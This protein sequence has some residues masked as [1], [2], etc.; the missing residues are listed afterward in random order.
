[1]R[2]RFSVVLMRRCFFTVFAM[3]ILFSGPAFAY[4]IVPFNSLR[5][6]VET[7]S[8]GLLFCPLG[9][10]DR[11][12]FLGD[13]AAV[14]ERLRR[15]RPFDETDPFSFWV[16]EASPAEERRLFK[17]VEGVPP[18]LV[19]RELLAHVPQRLKSVHYKIVLI[20][21]KGSNSCAEFSSIDKVSVIILGRLRDPDIKKFVKV[22]LHELGHSLGLRDERYQ[23]PHDPVPGPPNCAST[24]DEA[25][26]WWGDLARQYPERVGFFPGCCGNTGY[27]RPVIASIMNEPDKAEDFGPVNESYLEK[28]L[29]KKTL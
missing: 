6:P 14:R 17:P 21:A 18:F 22:F 3:V 5:D 4:K 19:R 2:E 13:V 10:K 20:D 27:I 12:A 28:I 7:P 11:A 26:Q 1:M 25:E 9:Y 23:D 15:T 8:L 24:R 16:L 29:L